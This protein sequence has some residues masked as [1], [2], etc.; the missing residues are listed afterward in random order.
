MNG[1]FARKWKE[2]GRRLPTTM[3]ATTRYIW[4]C[5]HCENKN[6]VTFSHGSVRPV[7]ECG[8][9][10]SPVTYELIDSAVLKKVSWFTLTDAKEEE[11]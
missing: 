8:S 1:E 7:L 4:T 5:P 11:E 2:T 9:C 10:D 3:G 6:D